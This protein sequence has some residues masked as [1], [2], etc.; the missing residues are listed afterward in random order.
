MKD[1]VLSIFISL[2]KLFF[3]FAIFLAPL[4]FLTDSTQN[5]FNIQI[6]ILVISAALI[7]LLSVLKIFTVK[8]FRFKLS[9]ADYL[10]GLFIFICLLSVA[11]N[12][13]VVG[14]FAALSEF[15]RRGYLLFISCGA[16][17]L[18]AKGVNV[19]DGEDKK[20]TP[21]YLF[22][23]WGFLW[24]F[25]PVLRTGA[26]VEFYAV[27]LWLF[28]IYICYR[29]LKH[30][31]A[32]EIA[33]IFIS[34]GALAALYGIMQNLGADIF[35][36]IDISGEF[37]KRAVSTFGNP[38]FLSSFLV[39]FL[40]L[41]FYYFAAAKQAGEKFYYGAIIVFYSAYLAVSLT[42]S[43]WLGAFAAFFVLFLFADFRALI[44]ANKKRVI[45]ISL[46]A[47]AI[48]FAWP[49]QEGK[50]NSAAVT[51]LADAR[52][53]LSLKNLTLSAPEQAL[54]QSYH[55]RLMMLTCALKTAK[56]NPVLGGGW[57]TFQLNYGLC[58]GGLILQHPALAKFVTQA[59]AAHNE[60]AEVL[61]QS[62]FLGLLSYLAFFVMFVFLFL[63][64]IK[65]LNAKQR[66]FYIA[67]FAGLAGVLKDNMLNITMQTA[68]V[69]FVFWF[70][71]GLTSAVF[72]ENKKVKIVF[73][74]F[75][76]LALAVIICG[77]AIRQGRVFES[78]IYAFSGGKALA[79]KNYNTARF[80]LQKSINLAPNKPEA[81]YNLVN[82]LVA[83]GEREDAL[84]A[85]LEAQKYFPAYYEFSFAAGNIYFYKNEI[86]NMAR[87]L[88]KT[89]ALNPAY[90][91]A[92]LAFSHSVYAHE[93]LQTQQNMNLLKKLGPIGQ[94][95]GAFFFYAA[96]AFQKQG[97]YSAAAD[98]A[99]KALAAEN[100][101][102][103]FLT[104]LKQI[105]AKLNIT[106]DPVLQK[107]QRVQYFRS[108]LENKKVPTQKQAQEIETFA[109]QYP[110]DLYAQ[111]TLAELYFNSKKYEQAYKILDAL[112]PSYG[113]EISLNY[114]LSY[115]CNALKNDEK[116]AFYLRRILALQPSNK[117]IQK[118]LEEINL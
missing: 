79:R 92:A 107:T 35:W 15:L 75:V 20:E 113:N 37:G 68:I 38:N 48:F 19:Y 30:F 58:Q 60:F 96:S 105:N 27:L 9:K 32:K 25:Y 22:I 14:Q 45:F 21:P 50:Y 100:L 17:W 99:R 33:D 29:H 80:Y 98:F 94:H 89:I 111:M 72:E 116:E 104:L 112:Y 78:D 85:A 49:Q 87:E 54:N 10:L 118:R 52:N 97:D 18:L 65:T 61:A 83:Q 31:N 6:L 28:G 53:E 62:G 77:F 84:N 67:L 12:Y 64:K 24:L 8:D 63:K 73:A 1:K 46:L 71:A 74:R 110:A 47:L 117:G 86:Q 3:I 69:G 76:M 51:R 16:G 2:K 102:V 41:V 4:V 91:P 26:T 43:S 114:A 40:P 5:P 44:S 57:G 42:R 106:E 115:T 23:L 90:Q 70:I 109:Q 39:L 55:Q 108:L 81:F 13:F 56:D 11:Y 66:L 59:N 7:A 95:E 34:V 101:N 82:T 88:I 93:D 36:K 103:R